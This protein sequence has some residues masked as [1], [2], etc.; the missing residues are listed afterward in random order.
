MAKF[1]AEV[2][3]TQSL[4][5]IEVSWVLA[6]TLTLWSLRSDTAETGETGMTEFHNLHLKNIIPTANSKKRKDRKERSTRGEKKKI[7]KNF[8]WTV[9]MEKTAVE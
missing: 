3:Y 5:I 2:I 1:Y 9:A 7:T 4:F 8:D 6:V